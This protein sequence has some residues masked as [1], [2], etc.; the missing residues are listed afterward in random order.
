VNG[1]STKKTDNVTGLGLLT[2]LQLLG[3]T[4]VEMGLDGD[5]SAVFDRSIE[6]AGELRAMGMAHPD[7]ADLL[8]RRL[9][10]VEPAISR[11]ADRRAVM[12]R[13]P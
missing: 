3:E 9:V 13:A 8:R 6:I 2:L 4:R 1:K 10:A 7:V 5:A 12:R 11:L